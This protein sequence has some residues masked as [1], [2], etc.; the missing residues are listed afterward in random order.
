MLF[1]VV[2]CDKRTASATPTSPGCSGTRCAII[3]MGRFV[4]HAVSMCATTDVILY[5]ARI[6]RRALQVGVV[7]CVL[8]S[9]CTTAAGDD[10]IASLPI[11]V[12]AAWS[13][14]RGN[15]LALHKNWASQKA[16]KA[17]LSRISSITTNCN[18]KIG[19]PD[20]STIAH[21]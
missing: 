6:P 14:A 1:N 13:P 3:A 21:I 18:L 9:R 5:C 12:Y 19:R 7:C 8:P 17:F 15:M 16:D 20:G 11:R 10:P 4:R 2:Q